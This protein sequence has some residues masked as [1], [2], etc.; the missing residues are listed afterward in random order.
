MATGVNS[1]TRSRNVQT[2]GPG[3]AIAFARWTPT[4]DATQT[5][6]ESAGISS[7]ERTAAGSYT[8]TFSDL[9]MHITP[10]GCS[11]V[12]NDTTKRH[13]FRVES[14]DSE[15]GTATLT[16]KVSTFT[17]ESSLT[18]VCVRLADVSA[19]S[20][21]Y[22]VAPCAGTVSK[23][24]SALGGAISTA[25]AAV[26]T[27]I[28]GTPITNGA[29]TVAYSG[30]AAGDVDSA[31]PTAAN[32]VAAG[33]LLTVTSDGASDDTATLDVVFVIQGTGNAPALSDT[34]DELSVAFLLRIAS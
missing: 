32:T 10:I 3:I 34:V 9:P 13:V 31:T 1:T 12:E 6:T 21:A 27:A 18:T 28:N 5:L 20:S 2:Y 25:N 19:A 30:S 14:T 22:A 15:A 17:T 29:L 16:H 4:T 7:I 33:N 11:F 8:V 26:T 23:V 24:Y